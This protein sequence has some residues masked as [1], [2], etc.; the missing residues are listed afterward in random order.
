MNIPQS[1]VDEVVEAV[2]T[3]SEKHRNVAAGYGLNK[4]G[5]DMAIHVFV[6][7]DLVEKWLPKRFQD[8]EVMVNVT[9]GVSALG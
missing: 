8:F 9:G 4:D 1:R 3:F 6:E 2:R 5:T 7:G